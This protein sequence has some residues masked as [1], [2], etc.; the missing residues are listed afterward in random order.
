MNWSLLSEGPWPVVA[1]TSV[2][3]REDASGHP[4]GDTNLDEP[5]RTFHSSVEEDRY[6]DKRPEPEVRRHEMRCAD[7]DTAHSHHSSAP[8]F[9]SY[10]SFSAVD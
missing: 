6:T 3:L 10:T 8:A 4:A 7:T 2:L 5:N 9:S 1:D